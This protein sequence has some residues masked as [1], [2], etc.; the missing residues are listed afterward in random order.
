M[1]KKFPKCGVPILGR[2]RNYRGFEYLGC[3]YGSTRITLLYSIWGVYMGH[4]MHGN[5]HVYS[6]STTTQIPSILNY[7]RVVLTVLRRG[8]VRLVVSLDYMISN[9]IFQLRSL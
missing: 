2:A 6:A 5:F 4:P 1:P 9:T 8:F 7:F 3:L